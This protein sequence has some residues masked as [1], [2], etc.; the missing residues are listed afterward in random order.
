VA[1]NGDVANKIGTYML[2]LAAH[3]NSIPVNAVLPRS[4]IDLSRPNGDLIAIEERGAEEVLGLQISG[5]RVAPDN[6]AAR[7]PAFDITPHHLLTAIVTEC[8]V[9]YPPYSVHLPQ[10]M[11]SQ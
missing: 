4:T 6:A 9:I 8:G 5:S 7:N 2:A 1:A 3:D 10:A 11:M